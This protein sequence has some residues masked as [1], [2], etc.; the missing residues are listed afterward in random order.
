[1][2]NGAATGYM[3]IAAKWMGLDDKTIRALEENMYYAMDAK[4]EEEAEKVYQNF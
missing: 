3:I 2:N 4:T 1:M